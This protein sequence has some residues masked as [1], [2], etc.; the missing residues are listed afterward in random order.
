MDY[1][2]WVNR[3]RE[4]LGT[5]GN[6]PGEVGVSCSIEPSARQKTQ[7]DKFTWLSAGHCELPEPIRLFL[8]DGSLRC[9]FGFNWTPPPHQQA[10]LQGLLVGCR[11]L[12]CGGDLCES[13]RYFNYANRGFFLNDFPALMEQAQATLQNLFPGF[14]HQDPASI[15][16]SML[17]TAGIEEGAHER[18]Q[19]RLVLSNL[20]SG[21]R[22][23]LLLDEVE[24]AGNV[25]IAFP[26][27]PDCVLSDTFDQFLQDWET[28]CYP[29]LELTSLRPWR[30]PHT[31]R[32]AP[33]PQK[34][35]ELRRMLRAAAARTPHEVVPA[36]HADRKWLARAEQ[37]VRPASRLPDEW[38]FSV[39]IEPPLS[40]HDADELAKTLPLGLPAPLREFYTQVT[41]GC[42]CTYHWTPTE[43]NLRLLKDVFPHQYSVYGGVRIISASRLL[44]AHGM[45]S[46]WQDV[47]GREDLRSQWEI[48]RQCVPFISVGNGDFVALHV[49]NDPLQLPVV[50]LCHDDPDLCVLPLSDSFNQF[51]SDWESLF[52]IGPE[53]WL[54]NPFMARKGNGPLNL[55]L[56]SV[57]RLRKLFAELN[58]PVIN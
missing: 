37:F 52:Y 24:G 41:S 43:A 45:H 46:W 2:S 56:K 58:W 15:V 40:E 18:Q 12:S 16:A 51:L 38:G 3:A 8:L 23:L 9:N 4:F 49:T 57:A 47:A 36:G 31:G 6:L 27:E 35:N 7:P 50:Y 13:A 30:D 55:K 44:D 10:M 48:W 5:L 29:A 54:L 17:T 32:L 25:V 39:T 14:P 28:A 22:L 53:I 20:E 26:G 34:S 19:G 1:Q 21:G 11:S 42:E 33:D